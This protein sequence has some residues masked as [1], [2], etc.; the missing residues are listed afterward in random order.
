MAEDMAL[1]KPFFVAFFLA[2]RAPSKSSVSRKN[3]KSGLLQRSW[4]AQIF[5][6]QTSRWC[7]RVLKKSSPNF[8]V[9]RV[10]LSGRGGMMTPGYFFSN[11]VC[12]QTKWLNLL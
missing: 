6:R 1:K 9:V 3:C 11:S 5:F 10:C 8:P 12:N 7:L 2:S 4:W